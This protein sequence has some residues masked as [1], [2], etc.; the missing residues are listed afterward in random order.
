MGFGMEFSEMVRVVCLSASPETSLSTFAFDAVALAFVDFVELVL[1]GFGAFGAASAGSGPVSFLSLRFGLA[2]IDF[3]ELDLEGLGA[4]RAA[5]V[6][7]GSATSGSGVFALVDERVMRFLDS[8]ASVGSAAFL[9]LG[10][11]FLV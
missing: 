11:I 1:V 10:G 2:F 3:D 5:F 6:G 8:G 9:R 4:F 7:A